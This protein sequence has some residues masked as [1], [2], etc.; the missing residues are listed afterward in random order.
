MILDT[1][2]ADA[3]AAANDLVV[4]DENFGTEEDAEYYGIAVAKE[5]TELL[6]K[7]NAAIADMQAD[8]TFD[9]ITA[10]WFA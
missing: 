4:L 8:G 5:N 1:G 7:I 9:E 2:V 3:F 10:K 6:D